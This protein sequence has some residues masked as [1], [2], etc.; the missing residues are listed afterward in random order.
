MTARRLRPDAVGRPNLVL[1][2]ASEI[3]DARI[4]WLSLD[5]RSSLMLGF[6]TQFSCIT[7]VEAGQEEHVVAPC[8]IPGPACQ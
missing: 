6:E 4:S 1:W 5:A 7:M 2:M 3:L 8:R